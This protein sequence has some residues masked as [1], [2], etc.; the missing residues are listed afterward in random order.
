MTT[1]TTTVSEPLEQLVQTGKR[2]FK[3]HVNKAIWVIKIRIRLRRYN[4]KQR[5]N[6]TRAEKK[7]VIKVDLT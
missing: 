4:T 7:K 2:V 1:S 6:A 3:A 5:G